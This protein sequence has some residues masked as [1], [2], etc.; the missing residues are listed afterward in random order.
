MYRVN[1]KYIAAVVEDEE[2]IITKEMQ[3]A[4][5]DIEEALTYINAEAYGEVSVEHIEEPQIQTPEER[6][7]ELEAALALLLEGATE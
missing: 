6:I 4:D 2:I 5:A 3:I 1:Y 7:A